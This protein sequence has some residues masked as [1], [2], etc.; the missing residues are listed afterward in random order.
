MMFLVSCRQRRRLKVRSYCAGGE[1]GPHRKR[2]KDVALAP[3]RI[4]Y[5]FILHAD[6]YTTISTKLYSLK[7]AITELVFPLVKNDEAT[8]QGLERNWPVFGQQLTN[9]NPGMLNVSRGWVLSEGDKNVRNEH[10]EFFI[11]GK[12]G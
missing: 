4:Y 11:I 8:L 7:M 1:D 2:Y 9:P 3:D 10:K 5:H 12:S 6:H